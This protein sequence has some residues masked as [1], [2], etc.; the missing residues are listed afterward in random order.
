MS[1]DN[2]DHDGNDHVYDGIREL[3][4]DLPLWWLALFG[5]TII[6]AFVYYL[7]YEIAGGLSQKQELAI[8]MTEIQGAKKAEETYTEERLK[9]LFSVAAIERGRELFA[10][11]CAACHG[12]NGGGVIGPNLTDSSWIHG[13]GTR[14]DVQAV[15]S[16]GVP[17]MGMPAWGE[18]MDAQDVLAAAA[19]VYSLK[20]TN[21]PGGRPAQG[22]ET[23]AE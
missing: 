9:E 18:M 16:K 5:G 7:H 11:K 17:A 20:N 21:V 15:V 2:R 8:A 1:A 3:D 22:H 14:Q 10:T 13:E 4:N 19:F 6:F 12:D 23:H